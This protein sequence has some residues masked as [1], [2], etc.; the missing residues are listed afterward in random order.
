MNARSPSF[1]LVFCPYFASIQSSKVQQTMIEL[2]FHIWILAY[3]FALEKY[4][5][6]STENSRKTRI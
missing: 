3:I 2:Y 1:T 4:L 6:I 5:F